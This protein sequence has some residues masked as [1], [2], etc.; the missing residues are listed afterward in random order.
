M[1]TTK[2]THQSGTLNPLLDRILVEART[3][4][5]EIHQVLTLM[6]WEPLP[7]E[8]VLE[9]KE[10]I[11][12]FCREL[13][14]R[15]ASCDPFVI[16]RRHRVDYWVRQYLDGACTLETAVNALHVSPLGNVG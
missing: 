5:R 16:R 1:E 11:R 15:Y 7:D 2:T 3:E 4:D 6:G 10:D 9:I 8:L 14:G 13:E 12:A